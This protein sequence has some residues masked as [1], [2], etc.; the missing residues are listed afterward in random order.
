M[1]A[2]D[3][4]SLPLAPEDVGHIVRVIL[5]DNPVNP[6]TAPARGQPYH[7][8]TQGKIERYHRSMKNVVKLEHY[9]D[10]GGGR[11]SA[12]ASWPNQLACI[13]ARQEGDQ[14]SRQTRQC[15]RA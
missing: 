4:V 5:K 12:P 3:V 13:V 7:Q 1:A 15:C 8:M 14:S 10:G 6:P 11:Y 9:C 2:G